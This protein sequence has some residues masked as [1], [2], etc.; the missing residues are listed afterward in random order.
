MHK[1][2]KCYGKAK[3]ANGL[4]GVMAGEFTIMFLSGLL[5]GSYYT[6][7]SLAIFVYPA[8]W[9]LWFASRRGTF[10][11]V[12]QTQKTLQASNFFITTSA[13]PIESITH[14]GT[15]GMFVGAASEIEITYR[16]SNGRDETVGFGATTFLNHADS[17]KILGAIVALNPQLGIPAELRA[18]SHHLNK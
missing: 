17:G 7:L 13:I 18:R 10:I 3:V 9:L 15:R 11:V 14:I 2:I 4:I 16:R 5:V 6:V 1:E 12:N 8:L